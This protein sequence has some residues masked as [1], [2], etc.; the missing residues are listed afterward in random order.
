L[1]FDF[2]YLLWRFTHKMKATDKKVNILNEK[3]S[4]K[5]LGT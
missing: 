4:G 3:L 2:C 5:D 1:L